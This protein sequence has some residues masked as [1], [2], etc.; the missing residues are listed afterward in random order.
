MDN[1]ISFFHE[2]TQSNFQE[3]GGKAA[4]LGRMTRNGVNVPGGFCITSD[5]LFYLIAYNRIQ[6]R[7]DDIVPYFN[8]ENLGDLGD[9]CAQIRE[10]IIQAEIPE[11]LLGEIQKAIVRLNTPKTSFV[12]VRSSVAVKNTDISSFPGMMDTYHYLKGEDVIIEHIRKC[13]ASLWTRRA[14]VSRYRRNIDQHDGLIAPIVQ[15]MVHSDIAGVMFTANP[16]TNSLNE[17]VIESNWGLGESVVSGKSANDFYLLDKSPLQLKDKRIARKN[18]I[19]CFDN[20]KGYGRKEEEVPSEKMH[21][22]TLSDD[23][24]KALGDIGIKLEIAFGF[25]QDIEWAY[26]QGEL[27]ILQTR[28]IRNLKA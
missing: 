4:N 5:A 10:L 17:I 27:F 1:Y 7:L 23:Q 13:W 11:D 12:A 22:P 14:V 21:I 16:I 2:M 25:P 9:K 20:K 18:I 15:K 3:L 6:E 19:F 8:Y 26:E 28:K 24:V